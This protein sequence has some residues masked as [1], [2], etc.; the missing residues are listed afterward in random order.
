MNKNQTKEVKMFGTTDECMSDNKAK[1][2]VIPAM[3]QLKNKL[4]QNISLI[5][6]LN[7]KKSS[8][9]SSPITASKETT[10]DDLISGT[11]N[12]LTNQLDNLMLRFRIPESEFYNSYLLLG[13]YDSASGTL[14]YNGKDHQAIGN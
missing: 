9:L 14:H 6:D 2:E 13:K 4:N 3:V 7:K 1:W 10:K 12:M 8:N 5:K 11:K